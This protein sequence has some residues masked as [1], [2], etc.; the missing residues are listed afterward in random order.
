M[1]KENEYDYY[2][3]FSFYDKRGRRLSIFAIEQEDYKQIW[4]QI[5]VIPCALNDMFSR[6]IGRKMYEDG[7]AEKWATIPVENG[8]PKNTFLTYCRKNFFK[9][10]T[11][12]IPVKV[13]MR[14]YQ[15]IN[16][17]VNKFLGEKQ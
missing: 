5:Q 11:I 6:K 8:K 1:E 3:T 10:V 14:G 2:S 16:E 7:I 17:D 12:E 13:L 4:L 9:E 15:D